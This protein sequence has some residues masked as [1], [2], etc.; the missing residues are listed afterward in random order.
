VVD[1]IRI[2]QGKVETS[3]AFEQYPNMKDKKFIFVT[4]HRREN[5]EKKERFLALYYAL[6]KLIMD[7]VDVCFL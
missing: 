1:A 2:S 5:T 3:K 6:K 4:I 7:G